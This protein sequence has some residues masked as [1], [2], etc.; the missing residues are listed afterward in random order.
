MSR[1]GDVWLD[2]QQ[3]KPLN[4]DRYIAL[5]LPSL[6]AGSV[7]TLAVEVQS[8]GTLAGFRGECWLSFEPTPPQKIDLAGQ[9]TPSLD[10]LHYQSPI[11]LPGNF[12]AQFLKRTV[13]IG[14][15]YR[16]REVYLTL[17]GDPALICVLINGKLVRRHHHMI[18]DRGSL[19]LTPFVRFGADNEIEIVRWNGAGKGAL[20]EVFLGFYNPGQM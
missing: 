7:H 11:N 15:E 5:D 4:A 17:D 10:G 2:G 9:W 13:S 20:R 14:D 3:V 18:G 19:N 8:P 12:N 1:A 6:Q 16:G